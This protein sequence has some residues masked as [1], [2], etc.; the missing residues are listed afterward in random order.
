[1][2][3]KGFVKIAKVCIHFLFFEKNARIMTCGNCDSADIVPISN[4]IEWSYHEKER[5]IDSGYGQYSICR[6]CGAVCYEMQAWNFNGNVHE[7]G[8]HKIKD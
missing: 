2:R 7:L 3:L 4:S 6:K 5:T 1:M 8:F